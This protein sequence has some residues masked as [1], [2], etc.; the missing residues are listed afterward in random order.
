VLQPLDTPGCVGRRNG[1]VNLDE[2][3]WDRSGQDCEPPQARGIPRNLQLDETRATPTRRCFTSCVADPSL[4]SQRAVRAKWGVVPL[5]D[6]LTKAALRTGCPAAL[7]P[8]RT[9]REIDPSALTERLKLLI[10]AYG[11]NTGVRA[12]AAGDHD[13]SEDNLRYIRSRYFTVPA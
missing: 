9:R 12:V 5:L 13:H 4:T 3:R 2:L 6:M 1:N 10:Y 11:T 7:T 8:L